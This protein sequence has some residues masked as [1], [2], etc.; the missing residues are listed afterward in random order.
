MAGRLYGTSGILAGAT[1][2]DIQVA[3]NW[4]AEYVEVHNLSAGATY[5]CNV[6]GAVFSIPPGR[7]LAIPGQVASL[8]LNGVGSFSVYAA[9]SADKLPSLDNISQGAVGSGTISP[10][11]GITIEDT[12][13]VLQVKDAGITN[14]KLA[15]LAVDGPKLANLAVDT[16]KLA[17]LA[18]TFNKVGSGVNQNPG[19][20]AT[21]TYAFGPEVPGDTLTLVDAGVPTTY[22][23]TNGGAPAPGNIGVDIPTMPVSL[24]NA[25][26]ANQPLV[27][28]NLVVG[29]AIQFGFTVT[30]LV[31]AGRTLTAASSIPGSLNNEL[32]V[33]ESRVGI[34]FHS[35]TG[36][37]FYNTSGYPIFTS[38][39]VVGAA[40]FSRNV[41][42]TQTADM[43]VISNML[44]GLGVLVESVP[45][46][47][48]CSVFL[49]VQY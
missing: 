5:T 30:S 23:F 17:D 18:V 7:K 6:N 13:L 38:G 37:A 35:F 32:P 15:N 8:T 45:V 4:T 2:V 25:V 27:S 39:T 40:A 33:A 26:A 19:R 22:E 46:G 9:E 21:V 28:T 42:G 11:D 49:A 41:A 31:Q 43:L 1:L 10:P 34:E 47:E 48:T 20:S 14:A 29:L 3:T 12:G 16:S 44:S 36:S 24:L